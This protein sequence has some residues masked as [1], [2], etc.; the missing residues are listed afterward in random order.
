[1]IIKGHNWKKYVSFTCISFYISV[2]VCVYIYMC[3]CVCV[4]VC[5]EYVYVFMCILYVFSNISAGVGC[6]PR[7]VFKQ[8]KK[9]EFRGFFLLDQLPYQSWRDRLSYYLL[10]AGGRIFRS[11]SFPRV[12][13]MWNANNVIQD[14]KLVHPVHFLWW[15]SLHSVHFIYED[16]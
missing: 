2:C 15:Y 6:F 8:F 4:C 16:H 11:I 3:V 12:L 5:C 7:S 10:I 1:M 9:F 14:L 13:V